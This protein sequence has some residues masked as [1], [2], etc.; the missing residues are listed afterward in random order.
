MIKVKR[1]K[2][3]SKKRAPKQKKKALHI[4]DSDSDESSSPP[5]QQK[6]KQ[7]RIPYSKEEKD[8]LLMGVERF[9]TGEW[10]K[11]RSYYDEVFNVNNR[12]NVNL[13]DLYRTLTK[14]A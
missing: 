7:K 9:G 6:K 11:I 3:G 8:T 2:K 1:N 5:V 13:K 14:D 4:Y 12:S 10:V